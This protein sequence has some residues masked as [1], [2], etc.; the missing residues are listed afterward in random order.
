[1]PSVIS[2]SITIKKSTNEVNKIIVYNEE[3]YNDY[4][5][6]YLHPDDSFD[7]ENINRVTPVQY[8]NLE[9]KKETEKYNTYEYKG[10]EYPTK[11]EAN[12][13]AKTQVER[14]LMLRQ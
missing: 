3:D 12:K 2:K 1:M 14:L 4:V 5:T 6:Y 8:K 13:A 11:E 9:A 10:V 7:T